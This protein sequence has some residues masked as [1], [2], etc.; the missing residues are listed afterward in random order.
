MQRADFVTEDDLQHLL[1]SF[2]DLLAG[3]LIDP[4]AP[5]KWLLIRREQPIQSEQNGS[6]RWWL[7]HLFLDQEGVP[8]LVE[9]KCQS[10]DDV[11]RKVVGQMLDYAAN[12][13]AWWSAKEILSAL[14]ITC[15]A[16]S[17]TANSELERLIGG[18]ADKSLFWQTVQTNLE[19][20]RLRLIFVTDRIPA[21]LRRIVEFLNHQM[22]PAEV[23]A[24]ELRQFEGEG[25]KTLVPT[26]YGR[27]EE[28]T[29]RKNPL[30]AQ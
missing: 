25:L 19:D 28:A 10:N 29:Q 27:T 7:D 13:T 12:A 16:K 23:L 8:T 20:G 15:A 22:S 17:T 26:V 1:A 4:E 5:R 21:E 2:P 18:E 30:L 11:R 14:S 6:A 3:T 9:V 24:V